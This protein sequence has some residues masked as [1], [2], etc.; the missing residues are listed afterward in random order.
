M[1]R[2]LSILFAVAGFPTLGRPNRQVFNQYS[3]EALAGVVDLNVVF[4]RLWRPGWPF[5]ATEGRDFGRVHTLAVPGFPGGWSL[6]MRRL[7]D[8]WTLLLFREVGFRLLKRLLSECDIIHSVDVFNPGVPAGSWARR[9]GKRHV[10]QATGSDLNALLPAEGRLPVIRGWQ[11]R[12]DGAACNSAAL[13]VVLMSLAPGIPVVETVYRGVDLE[14]FSPSLRDVADPQQGQG[15]RFLYLGGLPSYPYHPWRND[16]KGGVTL[17]GAWSMVEPELIAM[18]ASLVFA[19]PQAVSGCSESW[20]A[21]LRHP[22]SVCVAGTVNPADLPG[23]YGKTDVVLVPSREE[24]LPNVAVEA[25]A[26]GL[27]VVGSRAGGIPE[28][29]VDGQTGL[30]VAPG[31]VGELARAMLILASAPERVRQ[32]GAA[33]RV[34]AEKVFDRR[35]YPRKMLQLY[36]EVLSLPA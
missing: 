8:P 33:A 13:R 31:S 24:G 34:R 11:G 1:T 17:M 10:V 29:V 2:R 6:S 16:T 20:R 23:E 12:I 15:I 27:P 25:M 30:L 28:V 32:M 26:C 3:A 7:T 18:G 19:G 22:D 21:G 4:L 9:Y 35:M 36:S 14:R 5:L